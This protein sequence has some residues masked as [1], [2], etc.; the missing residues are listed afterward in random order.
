MMENVAVALENEYTLEQALLS[1]GAK[2]EYAGKFSE[3]ILPYRP[4]LD[5]IDA[6]RKQ[7]Q[8]KRFGLFSEARVGKSISFAAACIYMA[9]WGCKSIILSPP[10]LFLQL[11]DLFDSIRGSSIKFLIFNGT[12]NVRQ[13]LLAGWLADKGTAPDVVVMTKELFKKELNS[14]LAVGYRNLVFDEAH[15]GLQSEKSL[16]Y[17]AVK[18][19]ASASDSH[20]ITLST[21][22]PVP[23]ELEFAYPIISLI[24]PRAYAGRGHF[25]R[26]HVLYAPQKVGARTFMKVV[27]YQGIDK[28]HNAL[29]ANAH[30]VTKT[31]VLGLGAPNIQVVPVKLSTTHYGLYRRLLTQRVLE[32][33]GKLINAIQAQALRQTALQLITTPQDYG[34]VTNN[35]VVDLVQELLH[36]VGVEHKEKVVLFANYNRSVETLRDALTQYHPAVVYG[37]GTNNAKE[38]ERFKKDPACR[39]LIANPIAGGVGLT[40]GGVS[41]TAIFVEPVST[42]GQFDQA[43]SRVM[44]VGQTEPVSVYILKVTGTIS[45]SAISLM[46]R[47]GAEVKKVNND[48]QSLLDELLGKEGGHK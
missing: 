31:E 21:G 23:N 4:R 32:H 9:N 18:K 48:A 28:I 39:V 36:S 33:N 3:V 37:P 40:L 10:A 26:Q 29:Y 7:M 35:A 47:K 41:S 1:A 17:A 42:P 46:L 44:L 13:K 19:F 43:C 45:P 34:E 22:T 5:Q 15:M 6:I 24:N 27:G 14:L 12:P 30:R 38:A 8:F 2:P 20:R 16:T 25:N 11:E